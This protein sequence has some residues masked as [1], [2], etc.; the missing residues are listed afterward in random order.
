MPSCRRSGH[1]V[2]TRSDMDSGRGR[3]TFDTRPRCDPTTL[4][5]APIALVICGIFPAIDARSHNTAPAVLQWAGRGVGEMRRCPGC[6]TARLFY[7]QGARHLR[8]ACKINIDSSAL[9]PCRCDNGGAL[10]AG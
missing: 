2:L 9:E 7:R 6:G 1:H 8:P 4:A 10:D 5:A 3:G